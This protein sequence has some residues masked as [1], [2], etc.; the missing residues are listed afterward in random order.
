MPETLISGEKL[1]ACLPPRRHC[2]V[3]GGTVSY[4]EAG[5]PTDEPVVLLHGIGNSAAGWVRQF[6]SREEGLR[7]IAWDAPGY[8][9]SALLEPAAKAE[10]YARR[11]FEF[12][13]AMGIANARL[14][15]NSWGTLTALAFLR[16]F[17]DRARSL[18]LSGPSV[19]QGAQPRD[20]R[21]AIATSR[22][23]RLK[24]L[25]SIR[26]AQEDSGRLV[27]EDTRALA[28]EYLPL[29]ARDVTVEGF[30]RALHVLSEADGVAMAPL[31]HRVLIVAGDEDQ[32]AP[33]S[34]HAKPL[35]AAAANARLEILSRCGHL[36]HFELPSAFNKLV[37]AFWKESADG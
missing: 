2:A 33:V 35:A 5:A 17:P 25:G 12:M 27:A 19:G 32:I 7:L 13:S 15:A 37:Q 8:G 24:E 21:E 16:L 18:V 28:A 20:A 23:N 3:P 22:L 9:D 11:L 4:R 30:A 36:P 1:F 6:V 10:D 26:A 34:T 14:M 31:K 29:C